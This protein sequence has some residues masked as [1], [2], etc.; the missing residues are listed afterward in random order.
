MDQRQQGRV[1]RNAVFKFIFLIAA[2]AVPMAVPAA[3]QPAP[4]RPVTVRSAELELNPEQPD[5]R[6]LGSLHYLG[7]L[8]LAA[9]DDTFGG[10]SGMEVDP[11]GKGLWA[12]SDLGHWLRLDFTLDDNGLP[13]GVASARLLPLNDAE[14]RPLGRKRD[15]DAEALRRG[16]DGKWL[17]AFERSHRIWSYA[18]PG[19]VAASALPLPPAVADQPANGGI[20]AMAVLP[21]GSLLLLSEEHMFGQDNAAWLWRDGRWHDRLWPVSG[22]FHPTDATALPNGDVIVLE[23]YYTPFVGPKARLKRLP[24]AGLAD[25]RLKPE[26]L[27]EW[28]RPVSVDNME[29]L[30]ARRAADGS[31]WLYVMSDDNRNRLQRMLLMIF[32]LDPR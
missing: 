15:S 9:D 26:T 3:A 16:V 7:G 13:R 14:G 30:D 6:R 20:E 22:D 32:R 27:A 28:A 5:Q 29:A 25:T 10:Y 18:E 1:W 17:V 12:I 31:T 21:D 23:R 4:E 24:A 2:L 11:D 19:G 8:I